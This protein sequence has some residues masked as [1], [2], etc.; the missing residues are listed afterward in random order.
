[1]LKVVNGEIARITEQGPVMEDGSE[2]P[3]DVHIC[4]TGFDT[5]FKPRFPVVGTAG[6]TLSDAWK[7]EPK[8]YLGIAAT[9]SP[10][11]FMTLGPNCPIGN[12]PVLI[13]IEAEVDYIMTILAKFQKENLRSFEIKAQPVEDFCAWKDDFMANIIWTE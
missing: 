1:M 7:D 4:A 6:T 12:G 3:V 13:A 9:G 10:N 5:T 8:S 2:H 11:Y